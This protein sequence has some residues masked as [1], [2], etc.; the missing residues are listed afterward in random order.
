[1]NDGNDEDDRADGGGQSELAEA[2]LDAETAR[3]RGIILAR[4]RFVAAALAGVGLG[5]ACATGRRRPRRVPVDVARLT[6][7]VS[8]SPSRSR[9]SFSYFVPKIAHG[10]T[11]VWELA[12]HARGR[13]RAVLV[14]RIQTGKRSPA[15][16]RKRAFQ[17]LAPKPAHALA[18]LA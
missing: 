15:H 12:L 8:A 9:A 16:A 3:V 7:E 5:G 1:M 11:P 13:R 18:R 2:E 6:P 14:N 4:R 17:P 10:R